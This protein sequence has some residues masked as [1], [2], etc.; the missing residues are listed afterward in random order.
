MKEIIPDPAQAHATTRRIIFSTVVLLLILLPIGVYRAYPFIDDVT[1][2]NSFEDDWLL[3]KLYALSILHDGLTMPVKSGDYYA[4]SGFIYN[5]FVAAVFALTG[6]NSTHVYIAQTIL[7]ALSVGLMALAFKPYLPPKTLIFYFWA[8]ACFLFVDLFLNY[9]FRLLSENLTLFLLPLFY[10]TLLRAFERRSVFL[11]AC[12]GAFLGLCTLS[13]PNLVLVAPLTIVLL[14]LRLP[15]GRTKFCMLFL[16]GFS[17][18]FSLLPLRNYAV[19][20]QFSVPVFSQRKHWQPPPITSTEHLTPLSLVSDA[21]NVAVFY[22]RRVLFCMGLTFMESSLYRPRPHWLIMWAG[23]CLYLWR[24][25][26]R[27]G[28]QFW[29]LFTIGF[30]L[31]YLVPVIA[32]AQISNY[33][34]RMVLPVIPMALLLAVCGLTSKLFRSTEERLLSE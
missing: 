12:A 19:T 32:L 34:I 4:P 20:K 24:A 23:L 16:L 11:V 14:F 13:R 30:I 1:A 26:R 15:S 6:E 33:G 2:A 17:I 10:W 25:L 18:L 31:T 27:R 5:Y 3:Y 8:L 28:L 9:T 29:E 22:A 7:L 21:R